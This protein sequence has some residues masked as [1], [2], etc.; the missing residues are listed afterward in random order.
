MSQRYV[1]S[2]ISKVGNERFE[3]SVLRVKTV[4][5]AVTLIP[6][7]V[8]S[9][10]LEF[11]IFPFRAENVTLHHESILLVCQGSNLESFHSKWKMLANYTTDQNKK[12]NPELRTVGVEIL[13]LKQSYRCPLSKKFCCCCW[14]TDVFILFLFY[15]VPEGFE[16]PF[17]FRPSLGNRCTIRYTTGLLCFF[18]HLPNHILFLFTNIFVF[19]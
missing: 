2:S 18:N 10:K 14:N 5:V 19:I 11:G 1:I 7:I 15:V 4:R 6:N 3:L 9:P 16:P 12:Q 17:V 13:Y 8:D